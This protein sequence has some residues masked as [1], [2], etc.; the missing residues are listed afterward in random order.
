MTTNV[1]AGDFISH[2]IVLA[3]QFAPLPL[4]KKCSQSR[5]VWPYYGG[6]LIRL[7]RIVGWPSR[8][9]DVDSA[10]PVHPSVL[11]HVARELRARLQTR[12]P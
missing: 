11:G 4:V 12:W 2:A 3:F 1:E 5:D 6:L 9:G 7:Q 10:P 8:A